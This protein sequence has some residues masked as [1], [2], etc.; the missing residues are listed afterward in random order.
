EGFIITGST[1]SF[2]AGSSDVLFIKTDSSGNQTWIKTFGGTEGD[3]CKS[4]EQTKD[5]GYIIAG[6]TES[7]GAGYSDVWLIK[8]DINGYEE[9]NKTFG[10]VGYDEGYSVQ[11]TTDGGYIITGFTSATNDYQ[12]TD[13][14]LIKTDN[15]GIEE[16][17]KIFSGTKPDYGWSVQQTT[18]GGYIITGIHS[19]D[20]GWDLWLIKTDNNGIEEWNKIFG[21]DSGLDRAWSVKQ[22]TDGGYIVAGVTSSYGAGDGDVWLIKTDE[23]GNVDGVK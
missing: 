14:W 3:N 11:Q 9:W 7:Y 16:W 1:T 19:G 18:D 12:I 13:L 15:N 21:S 5:S 8:T 4:V 6:V 23:F 22:T 10:G 17:N 20:T 2:G